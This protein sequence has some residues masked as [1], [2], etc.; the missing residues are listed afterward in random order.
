[1]STL[2]DQQ[3]ALGAHLRDPAAQPPPTGI[4]PAAL[5]IYRRL[6]RNNVAQLLAANFPVIRATIDAGAWSGL[7]GGFCRDRTVGT[8]LFPRIGGEFV[9]H[10]Q[11]RDAPVAWPWLAELA[12]HEWT[13][14]ELRADATPC[15]PHDPSGDVVHGIP[16][17]SP[18]IRLHAHAWP[19]HRIGPG[20]VD[21]P[22][23]AA[24]T[25]L[26]AR[27]D[28]EGHVVFAELSPWTARLVAMLM[29]NRHE[30]GDRLAE[31]LAIEAGCP[32]DTGFLA[33]AHALLRRMLLQGS[34]LGTHS[35]G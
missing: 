32:G 9:R 33:Q 13:E 26:L 25:W 27:R 22:R 15:P 20:N 4:D 19:V 28:E 30:S 29:A 16:V 18:W 31:R 1:M 11:T 2:G 5:A 35:G 24:P 7:V 14:T 8:A 21:P 3:R 34:L 6:Y 10:L 17:A 12:L 23:P